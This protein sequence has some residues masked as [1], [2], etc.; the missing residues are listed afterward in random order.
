[1]EHPV[2]ENCLER[3]VSGR[4]TAAE[5]RSLVTHLLRGCGSC[6]QKLAALL[7]PEVSPTSYDRALSRMERSLADVW[8]AFQPEELRPLLAK[9]S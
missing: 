3:F 6:S 1:M 2:T 7:R 4:T 9:A 5:N 8:W